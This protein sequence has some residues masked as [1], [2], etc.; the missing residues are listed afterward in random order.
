MS[1][2]YSL[3]LVICLLAALLLVPLLAASAAT[4]VEIDAAIADGLEW[5]AAQQDPDG[6]WGAPDSCDRIART[7]LMGLKFNTFAIENGIDPLDPAYEYYD[8]AASGLAYIVANAQ[9]QAIGV[10]PAGDP[11]ENGNGF[12][13]Y[14]D[15][16]CHGGHQIYNT[17][18][19]MMAIASSGDF[20]SYG[21][22]LQDAVD[23]MAWA[24]ADEGCGDDD[25]RGG[26]RYGGNDCNSDNSNS[27]YATLGLGFAQYPPPYGFG[28]TVPQWVKDELSIWIDVIQDDVDHDPAVGDDG[29]SW[30]DPFNEWVN[31]LK[32]GNLLY[33][34]ALVGD[35]VEAQRVQDAIDYIERHWTDADACG[36]GWMNHGQAMFTMMKGLEAFGI[37]LLDL[38][39][40]TVP[41]H[42]WFDEVSTH[43]AGSQNPGGW[44]PGTCWG[45]DELDT[46]WGLLT[47]EKAIPP[48]VIP[49]PVDIKPGSCPNPFN[50]KQK[51]V[52]PVAILGTDEF[53]VTTIDPATIQLTREGEEYEEMGVW[54]L[55]WAYEDV[56]TP[57]DGELCDCHDLNGD[58]YLDLTLK[59]E[60][61]EVKDDLDLGDEVDNTIPLLITGQL[62]EEEGG[63]RIG[64]SDC[65]WVLVTGKK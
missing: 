19:A 13:K 41:E 57:F 40:D 58:G 56:G 29:G 12:G 63:M 9:Q 10:E 51:G 8:Q 42:D 21:V 36:S 26:W 53:D 35:P 25:H 37:E 48:I 11:D 31:I 7:G 17:G 34:M 16:G 15:A 22:L 65:V 30:Y 62:L 46:V 38:D 59:F 45:D 64:G 61:Q 4:E 6:G 32:T 47:L 23:Y 20:G 14:W 39:D 52:L 27:G 50:I 3:P 49:V 44:W 54:P 2:K 60:A 1:R 33:E 55:R 24:Q 18:I 28:L 5:L 43:L